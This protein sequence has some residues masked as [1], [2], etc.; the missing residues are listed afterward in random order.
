MSASTAAT[1]RRI[2]SI[3]HSN[4]S[5]EA[6]LDLI[7]LHQIEVLVDARSHPH[8][9]HAP[10]FDAR[11]LKG[12][13]NAAG[14]KYLYL[15]KELGG[16]PAGAEFYDADGHVL[17]GLVAQ[18]PLF[19]EGIRRLEEGAQKYRIALMCS[20]ENPTSCHRRL[21][22]GRVLAA[23]GIT[24]DHI[25]GDGQIQTEAELAN[26]EGTQQAGEQ[27]GLFGQQE[28]RAWRSTRSVLPRRPQLSS[29]ER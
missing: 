26:T 9:R 11:P 5:L 1:G 21:L 22:I 17:Y 16:R 13:V 27:P 18:S 6:F 15:G 25:R 23:R 7:R 10:H 14:I 20:E 12:A 4:Q 28:E 29:S 2:L 19:L 24:L 3:G 8:S